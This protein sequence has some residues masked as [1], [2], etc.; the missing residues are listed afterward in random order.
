MDG[1]K[2]KRM[3]S[4]FNVIEYIKR[5]LVSNGYVLFEEPIE[6]RC[7]SLMNDLKLV[8]NKTLKIK[9]DRPNEILVRSVFPDFKMSKDKEIE[10]S[11]IDIRN[12]IWEYLKQNYTFPIVEIE[13]IETEKEEDVA[14][15]LY[16][17][18]SN[19]VLNFYETDLIDMDEIEGVIEI[20]EIA[21]QLNS[22]DPELF[23]YNVCANRYDEWK[24][25][26]EGISLHLWYLLNYG[27]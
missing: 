23:A 6:E 20:M 16:K 26:G 4:E 21:E 8:D 1:K 9:S 5:R 24:E 15:N 3:L 19:V 7:P 10:L 13:S 14:L 27:E 2:A 12:F 18:T 11:F 22:P 17:F 25:Q